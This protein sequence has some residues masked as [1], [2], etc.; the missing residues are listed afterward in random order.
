VQAQQSVRIEMASGVIRLTTTGRAL[1]DGKIG[2]SI[3]VL[4]ANASQPVQARVMSK[5]AVSLEN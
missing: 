5:Q 3:P 2:Q 4:P 1:T